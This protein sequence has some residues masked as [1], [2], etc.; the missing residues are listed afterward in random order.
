LNTLNKWL[1]GIW[2]FSIAVLIGVLVNFDNVHPIIE[3]VEGRSVDEEGEAIPVQVSSE[4][5]QVQI[6]PEVEQQSVEIK[7]PEP[8]IKESYRFAMVGDILLHLRLAQYKDYSSSFKAVT[9]MLQNY[10]YLI[11]N[12]E[13][14]P[15]GNK[16]AL[17]GYP[18]FSSPPHI[19]RDIQNAGVDM[20]T[21]ANNHI[22]DKGEGGVRTVF[23]NLTSYKMPYVGVYQSKED[24]N[25]PRIIELGSIKVGMLAYTYGTNGLYLPKGS[26][27]IINY[28]DEAKMK[29]DIEAMK[30]QVDVIAVSMHWGSEY[31]YKENDYQRHL[32]NVLNQAGADI[33]FGTHPHVIQPYQEVINEAGHVTHV[34]YSIGN[35]FST[36]LTTPSTM[37]GGIASFEI[38]KENDR[39]TINNPQ[40]NATSVLKDADGVYRIYPLKDVENRAV[41]NLNWVKQILGEQVTVY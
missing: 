21:I 19:I 33:V 38:I 35:F 32:T 6:T 13:S 34:F 5:P 37:I 18:Q 2:I 17:S 12:Q 22:V 39:V 10:D 20:V 25:K 30:G 1:L 15:V 3:I 27:F 4:I 28:F 8:P 29:A 9:P 16:Y 26:P 40:F 11:A 24:A 14:P 23:E 31:V 7:E 41:K 36:I